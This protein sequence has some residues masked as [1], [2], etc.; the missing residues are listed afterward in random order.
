MTNRPTRQIL[1]WL[2]A[3]GIVGMGLIGIDI[4]FLS[5]PCIIVGLILT[6]I[7]INL[8]GI[9]QLW[10]AFLGLGLVPALFLFYDI[11]TVPPPCPLTGPVV[12]ANA[13]ILTCGGPLPTLYYILLA[14]FG[15]IALVAGMWPI[16]RKRV[17][18]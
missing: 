1:F 7:G 11:I 2:L 6:I 17:Q 16:V 15:G 3:G 14:C 12:P 4:F 9:K 18:R 13:P 10:A 5:I 8:W